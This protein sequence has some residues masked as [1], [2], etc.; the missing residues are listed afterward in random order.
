MT[1][2]HGYI[3]LKMLDKLQ[4][5]YKELKVSNTWTF[6]F[7]EERIFEIQPAK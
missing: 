5:N 4:Q 1:R 6:F 7:L 2:T 3:C